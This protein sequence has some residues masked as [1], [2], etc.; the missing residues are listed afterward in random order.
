MRRLT[1][2]Q[3][4]IAAAGLLLIVS[5]AILAWPKADEP[6]IPATV[7][8]IP[9]VSL[10][11]ARTA[12]DS[13]QAVFIDVRDA[14]AYAAGHVPNALSIPLAEIES[15]PPQIDPSTWIITYCT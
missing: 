1:T 9:R 4:L 8:E 7:A 2:G 11:D 14:E 6:P 10:T 15:D 13:A 12:F 3:I 5:A